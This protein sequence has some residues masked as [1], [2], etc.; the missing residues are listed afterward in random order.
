[1]DEKNRDTFY[2]ELGWE[3]PAEVRVAI[4]ATA[5]QAVEP[6]AFAL[7]DVSATGRFTET[8]LALV[9]HELIVVDLTAPEPGR[10]VPLDKETKVAVVDGRGSSRFRIVQAGRLVEEF[11]YSRRQAKRFGGLHHRCELAIKDEADGEYLPDSAGKRRPGE[12][13]ICPKCG[14]LIPDW[15]DTCPRCLQKRKVLWRLVAYA[16]PYKGLA[17]TGFVAAAVMTLLMLVPPV[18]TQTLID[19]VLK[20]QDASMAWWMWTL[21]GILAAVIMLRVICSHFRLKMLAYLSEKMT[22]DLRTRAYT[23]LQ[24]LSLAFFNKK[25]TGQLISRI[26]H[27]TDRLW[28]FIAFGI[29]EVV[30]ATATVIGVCVVMFWKAPVLAALTL[31]PI[32]VGIVLTYFHTLRMRRFFRRIWR[33]W[34]RMTAQLSDTL[35]GV[36][37]VKA[38]TQEAREIGCFS[39]RSRAVLD[40]AVDLHK[41]WTAYWPKITLL[42]Q[43]GNLIIWAYA[44]PRILQ[45]EFTLGTFVMFTALIWM[46]YGP[47]E[48]LGMMN[49]MFQRAATSAQ[50]VFDIIDTAP[51]IYTRAGSVSKPR[52]DGRVTFE[53]V[54]FS[55]DGIKRVLQDVSFDVKPGEVIGLAGPSGGGKTTLVNLICRF[56][57]VIAGR[58]L[59]DG[60]DV[61]DMDLHE[62]RSQTGVVL[63]EPYLFSGTIAENIA[64]G[65]QDASRQEI[66]A[67]AQ[68]AN[69]HDFIVGTCDGYDTMVG[70]RGQTL[71]GGERQRISIARAILN[72]PR[73]LIFDEATS[74]VDTKTEKKIQEAISRLIAGRTTFAIAHRLS[75]LRS[76]NRLIILEK[77]KLVQIGTHEEL[78]AEELVPKILRVHDIDDT[79][80]ITV[81]K[82]DTDRGPVEFQVKDDE[83][84][85]PLSEHTISIKD[86]SG[87]LFEIRDLRSLDERSRALVE[88]WLG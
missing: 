33:K 50:R 11:R 77:G 20:P 71:S 82:V 3:L 76:A 86:H 53:K 19:D 87:M 83:D 25:P 61:R 58:I 13:K 6:T 26:S 54:S 66:I 14:R 43:M 41:E 51:T 64:Y 30:M 22:H 49:R 79:F 70:E 18:L 16:K 10:S 23:H 78:H 7:A 4:R 27:D 84:I 17:I 65:R 68:A 85:R 52:I 12:E 37:V 88:D 48:E 55:Y 60:I 1:M 45:G 47:I 29:I 2:S 38:F 44:G 56:Y 42:L 31:I 46:F 5:A 28:D 35:P 74:S 72:N 39:E 80:E 36:R 67:A 21:L 40:E 32:P 15:T 57:D 24:K 8:W 59:I 34:S 9:D 75:T 69:A 62:L 81:W 63:Q 73:I